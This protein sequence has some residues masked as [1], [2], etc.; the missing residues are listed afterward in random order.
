MI[1]QG[2]TSTA[3]GPSAGSVVR[4]VCPLSSLTRR[5]RGGA[6]EVVDPGELGDERRRRRLDD[7]GCPAALDDRAPV[8]DGDLVCEHHRLLVRVGHDDR[9]HGGGV[10]HLG[11]LGGDRRAGGRV[12]RGERL[13]EQEHARHDGERS[14]EGDPLALASRE[15]VRA[16]AG[17]VVDPQALEQRVDIGPGLERDVRAHRHVREEGVVLEHEPDPA[18]LGRHPHAVAAPALAV[19]LDRAGGRPLEPRDQAQQGGLARPRWAD[20]GER[21]LDLDA[22]IEREVAQRMG[23]LGTK[24]GS[25]PRAISLAVRST[26]AL[27]TISTAP[28]PYTSSNAPRS[29]PR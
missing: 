24:R 5:A 29:N 10:D 2:A 19:A 25:L 15:A 1:S 14:R 8:H 4:T 6:L 22:G 11:E 28:S 3:T 7:L 18:A 20:D 12:E 16:A 26:A 17:E 27:M 13:V 9:R 21:A 23:Q